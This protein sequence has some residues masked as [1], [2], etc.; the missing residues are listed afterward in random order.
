MKKELEKHLIFFELQ[1]QF[2]QK[3]KHKIQKKEKEI[4]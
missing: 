2:S 4:K 3:N 1:I